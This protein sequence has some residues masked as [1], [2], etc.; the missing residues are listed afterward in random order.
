MSRKHYLVAASAT[1]AVIGALT[2][3][4]FLAFGGSDDEAAP[5]AATVAPYPSPGDKGG[6]KTLDAQDPRCPLGY[7]LHSDGFCYSAAV[8]P[9]TPPCVGQKLS[10][11]DYIKDTAVAVQM[12]DAGRAY[13]TQTTISGR[14]YS[15]N[16]AK[17]PTS[18][19]HRAGD[20]FSFAWTIST[21]TDTMTYY[22]EARDALLT[23]TIS[24]STYFAHPARYVGGAWDRAMRAY[25]AERAWLIAHPQKL[26]PHI[27]VPPA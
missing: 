6:V 22:Q 19:W 23:S 18:N 27:T 26:G 24:G 15:N 2:V 5:P 4:A 3:A 7:E 20:A 9:C 16:L 11:D 12:I 8:P 17:Y 10:T 14:S 1:L 25:A 13:L 21:G